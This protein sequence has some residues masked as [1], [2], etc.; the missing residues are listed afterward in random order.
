MSDKTRVES[1]AVTLIKR[2]GS[3]EKEVMA[4][5]ERA[6]QHPSFAFSILPVRGARGVG[7]SIQAGCSRVHECP[8]STGN[9]PR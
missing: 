8:E 3:D 2:S 4:D 9:V 7:I 1:K 5:S 6:I